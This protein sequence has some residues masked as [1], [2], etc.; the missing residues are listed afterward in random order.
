[1][2]SINKVI[3]I[4]NLGNDPEVRY[5]SGGAAVANF[6]LATS[7]KWKDKQSGNMEERTEWHRVVTW[8]RQAELCKEYLAKGRTVYLEGRLQTRQWDD[9]D[10]NKRYT[11]EVVAQ[12]I[13]FLDKRGNAEFSQNTAATASASSSAPQD[14]GP[15]PFDAEDDIPF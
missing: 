14:N 8:G 5:T 11:T 2:A 10:G 12:T 13:Q 1:M 3:L 7:E 15:P 9:K 6:S 4:G